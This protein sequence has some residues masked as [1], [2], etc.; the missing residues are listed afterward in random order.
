[1]ATLQARMLALINAIGADW[2]LLAPK[3]SP[4]FTG[5]V[6]IPTPSA[7]DNTTKAASTAYVQGE[8]AKQP[9]VIM[10]AVTDETTA[11]TTGTAKVT[12]RMPFAFRCTAV[13]GSLNVVSSSGLPQFDVNDGGVSIFSTNPTFDVSE[14][15]TV[16]AATASVISGS[17]A[18][19]DFA[20][21]AEV[22]ID[23]D[24]AGTGAKGLKVYLIGTR[25]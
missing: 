8:L 11:L 9:E 15:T 1:M 24:T 16:T 2:K 14:K 20:D 6:T 18:R 3:A 17:P 22:T 4:T 25:N 12:F 13:R 19:H 21:D 23:I 5:T 7:G 10:V